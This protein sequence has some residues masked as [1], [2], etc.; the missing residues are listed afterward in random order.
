LS[1]SYHDTADPYWIEVTQRTSG[2]SA[3]SYRQIYDGLGRRIQVQTSSAVLTEGTRDVLVDYDFDAY[4]RVTRRTVP[5]AVS[6]W[7]GSGHP[8]S[9][10]DWNQPK[11]VTGFDEQGRPLT[12][13]ATDGSVQ[14]YDYSILDDRLETVSTDPADRQT[15]SYLDVWGRSVEV[16]PPAGPV[17]EYSYSSLDLMETATTGGT[18]SYIDYDV[19]GR[20]ISMDDPDLGVW[21]YSYDALG[22]LLTQTD[23]RSCEIHLTYDALNRLQRKTY[24]GAGACG[25]TPQVTFTYDSGTYGVGRR[26][27][28]A[29][30]SGST[31]W[32]YDARG[33]IVSEAKLI[34]SGGT[35]LSQWGYDSADWLV[36]MRYPGG[37]NGEA[38]ETVY[39]SYHPQ[40]SLDSLTSNLGDTYVESTSYDASGRT[41]VRE[42]SAGAFQ[43]DFEYFPWTTSTGQGRLQEIVS[44]V[45]SDTDSLQKLDYDYDIVGNIETIQDWIAGT[46]QA[47][48]FGYDSLDRITS[49]QATGGTGGLYSESYTYSSTTGNL[50]N[51]G[52]VAYAYNDSAHAHAATHLDGAERYQYDASGNETW[53]SVGGSTY[54][55]TYDGDGRLIEVSQGGSPIAKYL[56]DG[57]GNLVREIADGKTTI[58]VGQHLEEVIGS[59]PAAT[60]TPTATPT[61]P[62]ATATSTGTATPAGG[63]GLKGEYFDNS[64]LTNFKWLRTDP[65]VNFNWGSGSPGS[66]VESDTFSVRWTGFVEPQF[67]ET[68]TF[69]VNK[70]DGA[71]LWINSQLVVDRW[72][73]G[74]GEYSGTIT[75]SGGTQYP[76]QLEFYE[77]TGNAYVTLSWSSASQAKQVVPSSQLFPGEPTPTPTNTLTPTLANTKTPTSTRTPTSTSVASGTGLTGEYFDS[78]SGDQLT[79]LLLT[80]TDA[81]INFSWATVTPAPGVPADDFYVR[82]SGYIKPQYAQVYTFYV[83]HD[84]GA[85]LWVNNEM[86]VNQWGTTG[87]HSGTTGVAFQAGVLY[88]VRLEYW[89]N[90]STATAK[91]YWQSSSQAKQII[92]QARLYISIPGPTPMPTRS[93]TVTPTVATPTPYTGAGIS[94]LV[95]QGNWD[96]YS[97]DFSHTVEYGPNRLL[98][99]TLAYA[100]DA[101]PYQMSFDGQLMTSAVAKCDR[102]ANN[103]CAAMYYLVDPPVGTYNVHLSFSNGG[104]IMAGVMT[105]YG[106]DQDNPEVGHGTDFNYDSGSTASVDLASQPGDLALDVIST[107]N[108]GAAYVTLGASQTARWSYTMTNP[109][110]TR[111]GGSSTESATGSTV[112]MS[113]GAYGAGCYWAY[114]AALFRAAQNVTPTP[115]MTASPS[116]TVTPTVASMPS[117]VTWRSYYFAG[118]QRVAMRVV[119]DPVPANNGVFYILG[120]HLGSTNVVVDE[121]GIEVAELRYKAWGE[122]RFT[123]GSTTTDYLYTGQREEA[124]IGLYYYRARWYDPYLNRWTQ[125]DSIVPDP[126]TAT[127]WDRY[128]YVRNNPV[129]YSDPTGHRVE[130]GCGVGRGCDIP[131]AM[132]LLRAAVDEKFDPFVGSLPTDTEYVGSVYEG[133]DRELALMYELASIDL[134]ELADLRLGN[135]L[136]EEAILDFASDWE[137]YDMDGSGPFGLQAWLQR[138]IEMGASNEAY[139][140]FLL[141]LMSKNIDVR[142][143]MNY[144][145]NF[146]AALMQRNQV[147]LEAAKGQYLY[148]LLSDWGSPIVALRWLQT[149]REVGALE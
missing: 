27:G 70:D 120:D 102:G 107:Y 25:T 143:W 24:S 74:C 91:L 6:V 15:S 66:G 62:T 47:Q 57:D 55:L 20:K 100:A 115:T 50:S 139:T 73:C 3:S 2:G 131:S 82:W 49:A 111:R 114:V 79:D 40:G 9:S 142:D 28:M 68:Y 61:A 134:Y 109:N 37:P 132:D 80:R 56:Y 33:R 36:W 5:Y 60:S 77:N 130:E 106:V 52:G 84:D 30:G 11:I 96:H 116:P 10:Q 133:L 90:V 23:A 63:S 59:T 118:A 119:G 110:W 42:F 129:K 112:N 135:T 88:P 145:P 121:D 17:V 103:A 43:T 44:G 54:D 127:D 141:R 69:Y 98:V 92:P 31:S 78:F 41:D 35:Y 65:T 83:N 39:S 89:D 19:A 53:R 22:N 128:A 93:P 146:L 51:K 85:R 71:R 76:I 122:T 64:D 136:T 87:E 34:Q 67:S 58:Y 8:F 144:E 13:T 29:D 140:L 123:S 105:L 75:L 18:T 147:A 95:T 138:R 16:D 45:T 124:S 1:V 14:Q 94:S 32:T 48:A 99:L 117:G 81:T 4:G 101:G 12:T 113:R 148:D 149:Q 72:N 137:Y 7:S 26:T 38:G 104:K 86:I 108:C 125:P 97:I 46:P 21:A 126:Y